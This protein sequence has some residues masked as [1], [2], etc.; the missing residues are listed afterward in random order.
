MTQ[1]FDRRSDTHTFVFFWVCYLVKWNNSY[2]SNFSDDH[3]DS[4]G[5]NNFNLNKIKKMRK[6]FN[7][8]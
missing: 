2:N 5:N 7:E 4:K 6:M 3:N 1:D 8:K